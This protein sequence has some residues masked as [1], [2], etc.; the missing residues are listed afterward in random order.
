MSKQCLTKREWEMQG[1]EVRDTLGEA[2]R[3]ASQ[4]IGN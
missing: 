1:D 4:R 3:R 2:Q